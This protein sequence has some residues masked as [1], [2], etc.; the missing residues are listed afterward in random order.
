[1]VLG[2]E[3]YKKYMSILIILFIVDYYYFI[4]EV[5]QTKTLLKLTERHLAYSAAASVV[6][7]SC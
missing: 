7:L 4:V 6:D 2:S 3:Q 5:Q 1:V